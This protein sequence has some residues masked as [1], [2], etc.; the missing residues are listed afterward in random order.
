MAESVKLLDL[1]PKFLKRLDD[2]TFQHEGVSF[3]DADGIRFL[4]PKCWVANKGPVGTHIVICWGPHVPKTT[5]PVPGRWMLVGTG[6]EDL[7]LVAGSSSIQLTSGC[8]WHGFIKD[9][10]ATL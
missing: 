6:Y 8:M 3:A 10:E 7:S 2:T 9:G 5:P 4:C 1:D